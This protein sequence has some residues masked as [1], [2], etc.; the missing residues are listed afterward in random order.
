[1]TIRVLVA[2]DQQLVRAGLAGIVAA[3]PDLEVVADVADGRQAVAAVAE[4]RP[5]V[6]LMDIR[7]PGM[8][9]IEATGR[10]TAAGHARVLMLTTFDLDEYVF[11]ALRAGASGF[12]VKDTPPLDL[13]TA[14]R[15]V[16]FGEALLAPRITKRL[17]AA[18]IDRP[19]DQPGRRPAPPLPTSV[20]SREREVLLL[21]AEGLSNAEIADRLFIGTGTVKTHIARLLTKLD[22]RDRVQLV[23]LAYRTGLAE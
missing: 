2:D 15:T 20:T 23:I 22:A 16:A 14:I 6:V 3:A 17:I 7:M 5:D 4:H 9:G 11:G 10:I 1:M 13:H 19:A 21:V 12:L 18:Y 8:D